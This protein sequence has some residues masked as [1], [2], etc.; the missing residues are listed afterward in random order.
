MSTFEYAPFF[1]LPQVRLETG[2]GHAVSLERDGCPDAAAA[3]HYRGRLRC[4]LPEQYDATDG[5]AYRSLYA[6]ISSSFGLMSA[7]ACTCVYVVHVLAISARPSIDLPSPEQLQPCAQSRAVSSSTR[8][9]RHKTFLSPALLRLRM[10]LF[11]GLTNKVS[12][13]CSPHGLT[14]I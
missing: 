11:D 10:G 9:L 4:L 2:L 3:G 8:F 12:H 6:R 7:S 14:C 13:P 1:F 5:G